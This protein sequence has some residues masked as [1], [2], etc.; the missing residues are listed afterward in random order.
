MGWVRVHGYRWPSGCE[1]TE[2]GGGGAKGTFGFC[3]PMGT[4]KPRAFGFFWLVLSTSGLCIKQ[5]EMYIAAVLRGTS[6]YE[7]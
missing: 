4:I 3:V 6:Q 2:M 7:Q 5:W 1:P